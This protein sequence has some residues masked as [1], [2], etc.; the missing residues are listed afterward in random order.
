MDQIPG[1][2]QNNLDSG[3]EGFPFLYPFSCAILTSFLASIPHTVTK[4]LKQKI[5]LL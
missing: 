4:T 2:C 5:L 1:V 3:K